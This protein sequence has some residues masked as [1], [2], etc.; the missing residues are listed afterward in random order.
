MAGK[1]SNRVSL[2]ENK[3]AYRKNQVV[4]AVASRTNEELEKVITEQE[5]FEIVGIVR[6]HKVGLD[7]LAS[8]MQGVLPSGESL[9]SEEK[10]KPVTPEEEAAL[11]ASKRR[12]E[13]KQAKSQKPAQEPE[14]E[15]SEN[16]QD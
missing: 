15:D 11:S 16:E 12:K 10:L 9:F 14:Q 4:M 1:K 3:R 5:N 8:V 7:N 2:E 6:K 13:N